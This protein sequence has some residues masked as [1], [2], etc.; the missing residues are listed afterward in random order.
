MS[1]NIIFVFGL[2][3]ILCTKARIILTSGLKFVS[4]HGLNV[5]S[6][7]QI[8]SQLYEIVVSS[9]QVF[10]KQKIRILLPPDYITSDINCHYPTLYLLHGAYG[11]ASDW[12]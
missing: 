1:F 9:N 5:L 12:T 11:S 10:D 8:N 4:S 3:V 7:S 2:V 6:A